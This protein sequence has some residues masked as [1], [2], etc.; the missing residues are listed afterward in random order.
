MAD[1]LLTALKPDRFTVSKKGDPD[2]LLTE[3]NE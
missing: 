3:F 1:A 2:V